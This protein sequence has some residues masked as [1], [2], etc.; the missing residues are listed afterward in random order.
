ME[1]QASHR[2]SS[3]EGHDSSNIAVCDRNAVRLLVIGWQWR[4][5][6]PFLVCLLLPLLLD[7]RLG[8]ETEARQSLGQ[9][10]SRVVDQHD[11]EDEE[12]RQEVEDPHWPARWR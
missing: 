11:D 3:R 1:V 2:Q 9:V 12:A 8:L 10:V 7:E 5:N 6:G 4:A